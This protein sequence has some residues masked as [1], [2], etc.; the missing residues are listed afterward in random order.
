MVHWITSSIHENPKL[1]TWGEHVMYRNCFWHS[2]QFLFTTCSPHVLQKEELLTKDLPVPR[3]SPNSPAMMKK[4]RGI[5]IQLLRKDN[6]EKIT[7]RLSSILNIYLSKRS[8]RY[9]QKLF[10]SRLVQVIAFSI[11]NFLSS[12]G[13]WLK[14]V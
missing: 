12:Q 3:S 8:L 13:T 2:E 6:I 1:R 11:E 9:I 7:H 10:I 14:T 5:A 4:T